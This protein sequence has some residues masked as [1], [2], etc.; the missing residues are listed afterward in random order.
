MVLLLAVGV[1]TFVTGAALLVLQGV[2][3]ERAM[4]AEALLGARAALA[5]DGAL[6]WFLTGGWTSPAAPDDGAGVPD[7]L[8]AVPASVL[9]GGPRFRQ[10]GEIRV[11]CLGEGEV[12][13]RVVWKLTIQARH[14]LTA[15]PRTLATFRQTREA[16]VTTP[17]GVAGAAPVLGGWRTIH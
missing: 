17:A 3:R 13:G 2:L 1:L 4:E 6:A 14:H 10:D 11:R 16:Y 15:G 12:P 8:L 7:A 5:A 9:D